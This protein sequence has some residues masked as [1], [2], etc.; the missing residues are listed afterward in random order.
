MPDDDL[1]R[2][3]IP[4][5]VKGVVFALAIFGLFMLVRWIVAAVMSI[6]WVLLAIGAVVVVA[7]VLRSASRSKSD[8]T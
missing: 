3:T 5:W 1:K 8:D 6:F 4:M 7:L 2:P